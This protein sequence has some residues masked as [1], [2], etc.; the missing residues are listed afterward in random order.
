M[1]GDLVI[2]AHAIVEKVQ[3]I[4][5]VSTGSGDNWGWWSPPGVVG[6]EV[7]DYYG[8]EWEFY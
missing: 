1:C 8:G 4:C 2:D 6:V 5:Q 3:L 7:P